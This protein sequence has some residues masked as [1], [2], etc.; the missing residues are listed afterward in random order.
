M[1][2]AVDSELEGLAV[3]ER[4]EVGT[5]GDA[6]RRGDWGAEGG[7]SNICICIGGDVESTLG[8][9]GNASA[10]CV[11]HSHTS[12]TGTA[13]AASHG[14]WMGSGNSLGDAALLRFRPC[15]DIT[16]ACC[17]IVEES[18]QHTAVV[19]E[20]S[21]VMK[22]AS[23]ADRGTVAA[24]HPALLVSNSPDRLPFYVQ[25][26]V[27]FAAVAGN[28]WLV[29]SDVSGT[30]LIESNGPLWEGSTNGKHQQHQTYT[31]NL[32]Y[33]TNTRNRSTRSKRLCAYIACPMFCPITEIKF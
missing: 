10:A 20:K 23:A 21:Y 32:K 13:R 7:C 26:C 8:R 27:S 33:N 16:L 25:S 6:S 1:A 12:A 19:L 15:S 11:I 2:E 24:Q 9:F 4:T 14:N 28:C 30:S 17:C 22:A 29:L 5:D 3:S 31:Q 18:G